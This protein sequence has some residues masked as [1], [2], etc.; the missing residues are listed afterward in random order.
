MSEMSNTILEGDYQRIISAVWLRLTQRRLFLNLHPP[1]YIFSLAAIL[2]ENW[3]HGH[4][5]GR[6]PHK[7]HSA[8]VCLQLAQ[9]F[10][11]RRL[12][13]EMLTDGRRTKRDGD[14]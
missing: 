10:L 7:D 14:S 3:D 1:F 13:C 9:W 6:G 5:F 8:K 4:I 11:R 2:V 12:K